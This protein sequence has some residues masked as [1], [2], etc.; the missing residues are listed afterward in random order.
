MRLHEIQPARLVYPSDGP[1]AGYYYRHPDPVVP[2]Y[3]LV[4]EIAPSV[5]PAISTHMSGDTPSTLARDLVTA[6]RENTGPGSTG[7]DSEAQAAG[8]PGAS[9]V[10]YGLRGAPELAVLS[11]ET[12]A[13]H[14]PRRIR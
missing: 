12:G 14:A 9:Q 8:D 13:A 10:P 3:W 6:S 4:N 2:V 5:E 11:T 1:V 7:T